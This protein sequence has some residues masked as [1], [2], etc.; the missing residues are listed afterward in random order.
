MVL[1][2]LLAQAAKLGP[3]IIYFDK[4]RG[5]ELFVRAIG[6]V[7]SVLR[8]G[9]PTGLN[10][11]A[12]LDSP[13]NRGFLRS[14]VA[15][16]LGCCDAAERALIAAA[17]DAS[18]DAA[19]QFRRLKYFRELL[20]GTGRP[21]AGDLAHRLAAW[22]EGGERGWLFDNAT[23]DFAIE[24]QTVGVDM[25]AILDDPVARTAAMMLLFHRVEE[26]L[27]GTPAII[28]VDEGW[29]ALD[30]EVFVAA[31]R[32]WEKTIR[33]RGG[34]VGFATQNAGDALSSRIGPAII[35]QAA[36]QIFMP[37]PKAQAAD[38]CTGFGLTAHELDLIRTLPD[39]T[40]C[41]LV[42]HGNDSVIARL[43]L[44]GLDRILTIL[45]GREASVRRLDALRE[46]HG[47]APAAWL[48]P[49]LER[50]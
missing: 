31:I 38:Y 6:G 47:D 24:A 45:S 4:D 42:K 32:D 40:R 41:F 34:I 13:G 29:K 44:T 26:R 2:F 39:T 27:D 5:A 25:T 48:E 30:D 12:L 1:T 11:L 16:L 17:V 3:R 18:Y 33:K 46:A 7:Y 10:P 50:A 35:E 37:N 43:D 15:E 20:G 14:F 22:C 19:P 49:L 36:T 28:V 8:P 23:D 21:A 9:Q